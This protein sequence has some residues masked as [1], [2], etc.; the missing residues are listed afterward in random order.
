MIKLL[1]LSVL[2]LPFLFSCK[3]KNEPLPSYLHI[4]TVDFNYQN[5][6]LVGNGGT[7]ITDAWVY[8][9]GN[10]LGVFEL[11]ATIALLNKGET[12]ISVRAGIKL[13]GISATREFYRYYTLWEQPIILKDLDTT[14]IQPE[15]QYSPDDMAIS[16]KEEFQNVILSLDSFPPSDVP[17]VRTNVVNQPFYL[18]NYVGKATIT[19]DKPIFKAVTSTLFLVPADQGAPIY[20]ELDYKCNQSFVVSAIIKDP[21]TGTN[22]TPII[23]LR[24]TADNDGLEWNHIYIDLTDYFV[25]KIS[26]T[27]FGVSFAAVYDSENS[28]GLVFLDNVKVVNTY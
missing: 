1:R 2:F 8:D 21:L 17:L 28:E 7:N 3:G 19:S 9:N 13:N 16:F 18:D 12:T 24:S 27:G 4:E 6:S 10:L 14:N 20:L 15:T 25:G 26:A 11:P 5:V 22:E 23:S